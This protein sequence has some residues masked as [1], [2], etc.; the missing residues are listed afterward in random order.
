MALENIGHH[1][2]QNDEDIKEQMDMGIVRNVLLGVLS[3]SLD[4]PLS[5]IVSYA[6]NRTS[7][8]E[9][10]LSFGW[11]APSYA[12]LFKSTC[13]SKEQFT[14]KYILEASRESPS[15]PQ[16]F[17]VRMMTGSSDERGESTLYGKHCLRKRNA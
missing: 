10:A 15:D 14:Q 11:T 7:I 3:T 1:L 16:G 5:W 17:F 4:E 13:I 2:F 12:S 6:D 8:C 9:K